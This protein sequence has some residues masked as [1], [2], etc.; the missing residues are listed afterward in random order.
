MYMN[1]HPCIEAIQKHML[2][3]SNVYNHFVL[4]LNKSEQTKNYIH[5]IQNKNI[6]K[7]I[8]HIHEVLT[9]WT[10]KQATYQQSAK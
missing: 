8:E 5:I 2:E 7:S 1:S 4:S 3:R 10:N 9:K 6:V